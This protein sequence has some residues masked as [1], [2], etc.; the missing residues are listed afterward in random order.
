LPYISH[1]VEGSKILE[2]EGCPEH[3]RVC[4]RHTGVG[5]RAVDIKEQGLPLPERDMLPETLEEQVICYADKWYSK[6]PKKLWKPYKFE[7]ITAHFQK[8]S[9]ADE[10]IET[11]TKWR[12]LSEG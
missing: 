3:A 10:M 8:F 12:E 5:I 9:R 1:G 11:F 2:A 6:D 7:E 4:E